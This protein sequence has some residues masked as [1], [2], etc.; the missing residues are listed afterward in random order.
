MREDFELRKELEQLINQIQDKSLRKK[1]YDLIQNPIVSLKGMRKMGL[2][3]QRSPAGKSR[4][5]S[6]PEGLVDH[7]IA[8][9]RV[10]LALCDSVEKT[11]HGKVNRDLVLAGVLL[12]DIFKPVTY[13]ERE[14]GGY[15]M[16]PLGERLDH[17][18]LLLGELYRRKMPIELLH[19]VAAHHGK[20]GPMSPRTIEAL[21]VHVA[22]VSDST[23]NGEVQDAARFI[24]RDCTGEELATLTS[25]EAF[26]IVF[27]KQT[28]GCKGVEEELE[29]IKKKRSVR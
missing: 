4:H 7:M 27:A 26:H 1:V 20:Y 2:P 19:I 17:L 14:N 8:T 12:H 5:H 13:V 28:K 6:Y 10:A 16:S 9:A 15:D 21:I 29:R 25:E 22:D 3:L 18:S 24:L 11:Y 23:L